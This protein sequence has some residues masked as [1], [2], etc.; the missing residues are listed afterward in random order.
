[1][2][3]VCAVALYMQVN[4]VGMRWDSTEYGK[5]WDKQLD[6]LH[7][8]AG[9]YMCQPDPA[10]RWPVAKLLAEVMELEHACGPDHA[11]T[12]NLL[13]AQAQQ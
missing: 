9:K 8:L 1:M 5:Y 13:A 10:Q 4:Y 11:K 3:S 6:A 2:T 7:E 12:E